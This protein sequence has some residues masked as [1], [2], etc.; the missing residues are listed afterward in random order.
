MSVCVCLCE[1]VVNSICD[2]MCMACVFSVWYVHDMY[3]L[4]VGGMWSI[5]VLCV[6]YGEQG[7]CCVCLR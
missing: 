4:F 5:C 1:C 6:V 7:V 2:C 3:V